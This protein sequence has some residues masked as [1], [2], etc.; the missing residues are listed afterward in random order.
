MRKHFSLLLAAFAT[1]LSGWAATTYEIGSASDL[2]AFAA[3]V[4]AG[5]TDACAVLTAD[6]DLA[7]VTHTPIGTADW[8]FCGTIDGQYHTISNLNNMLC[9]TIDGATLT[10]IIVA[11]GEI[12]DNTEYCSKESSK[13]FKRYC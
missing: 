8:M 10:K 7:D 3:K 9:G 2:E 5:E 12:K 4:N 13:M 11:S 1:C 6:I